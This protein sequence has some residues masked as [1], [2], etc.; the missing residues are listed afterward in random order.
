MEHFNRIDRKKNYH[1]STFFFSELLIQWNISI[2][3]DFQF[4]IQRKY[5]LL[6]CYKYNTRNRYSEVSNDLK[7]L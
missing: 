7:F 2:T 4:L 6:T 5:L 1:R 3:N